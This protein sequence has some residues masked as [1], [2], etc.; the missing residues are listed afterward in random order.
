MGR[1]LWGLTGCD[2]EK[3]G[4]DETLRETVSQATSLSLE[5][6]MSHYLTMTMLILPTQLL[7]AV[8]TAAAFILFI[9]MFYHFV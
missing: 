5:S 2:R 6:K 8:C 4:G 9:L 7:Y 1:D 3:R